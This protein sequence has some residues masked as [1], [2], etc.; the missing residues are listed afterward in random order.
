MYQIRIR[1]N[2]RL[3]EYGK[4]DRAN[5]GVKLKNGEFRYLNWR[6]FTLH[7]NQPVKLLIE[8]FTIESNWDPRNPSSKM[9]QWQALDESEFLLGSYYDEYVLTLMPFTV[10]G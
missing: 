7:M 8:A 2:K 3:D 6:G 4:D 9:P 1:T 10:F 5:V